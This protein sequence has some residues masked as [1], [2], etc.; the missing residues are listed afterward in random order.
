MKEYRTVYLDYAAATPMDEQVVAAM[1]PYFSEKFFNPSSPYLPALDVKYEYNQAK[2]KIAKA[3]GGVADELVVTAGA[4][5]SIAVAFNIVSDDGG[6]II[7]AI[8]HPSVV[9]AA[10]GKNVDILPVDKNGRVAAKDL[11]KMITDKTEL[12]SI[13]LANNEIGTIQPMRELA[14]IVKRE[15]Q[16]RFESGEKRP[17]YLHS[18]AS[19]ALGV[20]DVNVARMGLD[21][22]TISAAKV[23]GPKQVAV[24]W[25]DRRV[26]LRPIVAGG[27]QE[28]GIRGGTENVAGVIGFA[29]AIELA[30][31]RRSTHSKRM[32]ELRDDLENRLKKVFPEMKVNGSRKSR[33]PQILS[34]AWDGI[35]AER[36]IFRLESQGVFVATGSACA[37]NKGTRSKVLVAIGLSDGEADGS[38]RISLGRP[39]E[40]EDIDYAFEK[41]VEAVQGERERS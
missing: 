32:M 31:R 41:I 1:L 12:V 33:L 7:S 22:V 11:S 5:E 8:E 19:Q 20:L 35:D 9:S 6:V 25:A 28:R 3:L 36:L 27:L 10:Q 14:E 37:A 26:N 34:V 23:Y 21:M 18:D 15:R 30:D 2:A 4:T 40:K 24:L 39:T 17:I 29:R 13:G 16:R 38:L